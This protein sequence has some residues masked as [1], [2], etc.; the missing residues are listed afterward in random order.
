[1]ADEEHF[2]LLLWSL[3][4][5]RLV[6]EAGIE[7]PLFYPDFIRSWYIAGKTADKAARHYINNVEAQRE[8]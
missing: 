7:N 5:K 1:M 2:T 3:E 8:K 6:I 4:V